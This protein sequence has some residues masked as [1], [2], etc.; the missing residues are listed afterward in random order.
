MI[1][2]RQ[3]NK[4]NNNNNK[5]ILKT[6]SAMLACGQKLSRT[7]CLRDLKFAPFSSLLCSS[8][9]RERISNPIK[10]RVLQSYFNIFFTLGNYKQDRMYLEP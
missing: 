8:G 1:K 7:R 2:I 3:H 4:K 5:V 6:A 9:K 10:N